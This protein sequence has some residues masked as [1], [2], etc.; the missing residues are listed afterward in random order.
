MSK[1]QIR[2][3]LMR[4][5]ALVSYSFIIDIKCTIP[6]PPDSSTAISFYSLAVAKAQLFDKDLTRY[7]FDLH[8]QELIVCLSKTCMCWHLFV[9]WVNINTY[10]NDITTK[11]VVIFTI[12]IYLRISFPLTNRKL[13]R[14]L[15]LC[16]GL[17]SNSILW[18]L[19]SIVLSY[20][21]LTFAICFSF[22]HPQCGVNSNEM[23]ACQWWFTLKCSACQFLLVLF[24]FFLFFFIF[25]YFSICFSV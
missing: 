21:T 19:A 2:L 11:P 15:H 4:Q 17:S 6:T 23:R 22:C 1:R 16:F 18:H 3:R 5:V 20:K 9:S 7:H 12:V 10:I 8:V 24:F 25:L 14:I 13:V